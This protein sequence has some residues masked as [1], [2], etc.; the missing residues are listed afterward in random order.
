MLLNNSTQPITYEGTYDKNYVNGILVIICF[1][2]I[3]WFV[4][5]CQ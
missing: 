1:Q 3:V 5:P 2:L 4:L